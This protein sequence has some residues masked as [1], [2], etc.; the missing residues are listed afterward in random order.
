MGLA[1][2][3]NTMTSKVGDANAVMPIAHSRDS[4]AADEAETYELLEF[5]L[6][7]SGTHSEKP[8]M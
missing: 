3:D 5:F 7:M 4:Y 8:M 1:S 2:L 6:L